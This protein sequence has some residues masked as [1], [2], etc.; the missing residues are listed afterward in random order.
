MLQ[1]SIAL[2][3]VVALSIMMGCKNEKPSLKGDVPVAVKAFIAAFPSLK[4]PF[5]F[6]DTSMVRLAD[7][8]ELGYKL[9]KQFVPDSAMQKMELNEAD[10]KQRIHPF[11]KIIKGK[12]QYLLLLI[13]EKK[14]AKTYSILLDDKGQFKA[15]LPLIKNTS[16]DGY[17]TTVGINT[18]P[19][20]T[21]GREKKTAD[22]QYLYSRN[23]LAYNAAAKGFITVMSESNEDK[24]KAAVIINPIDTLPKTF[25]YSG[26]YKRDA[27]NFISLRDT[28]IPGEYA[29]FI[30][31][32]KNEGSCV[33][34]LKA[35][36]KMKD[37]NK[38]Q[39]L[40]NGDACIIDFTFKG[41]DIVVK[42]QGT[43]GNHRGIKCFFND[44]Y[45]KVKEKPIA[46]KPIL[47]PQRAKKSK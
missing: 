26:D 5:Q 46:K 38:A 47:K 2:V 18:E 43:C 44:T 6:A 27:K 45:I 19:T 33:G 31:F 24:K 28:K 23:S 3:S 4:V 12:E 16:A 40:Q 7:T 8:T 20:F 36:L 17:A 35:T 37:A 13:K 29:F 9:I 15:I 11:G 32:E 39:Y 25:K 30:H 41:R 22:N 1:K 34:E 42:E 14:L 21:I 10:K